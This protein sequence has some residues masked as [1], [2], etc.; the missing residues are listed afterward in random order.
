MINLALIGYGQRGSYL[1]QK[2]L[3][4]ID[5]INVIS[6]CDKYGDRAQQ[7][8]K[9]CSSFG[10][11]A[12]C[13]TDYKEALNVAGIDGAI[14]ATSW[15]THSKIALYALEKGIPVGS[16]VAGEYSV[17][18]CFE[19]VKTQERTKTP[20]MFLENCCYGEEELL[21]TS[22]VRKN[23]L[24]NVVYC[25]GA[26]A[27]DLRNEVAYGIRNRHYRF[28]N[29]VH[30]NCDN[31][32]THE[33][34]PIARLLN[35]NRGNRLVSLT[36]MSS[37][38]LGLKE[39]IKSRD[40]ADDIM[41]NAEFAQGDVV[42]TLIKCAGGEM[43]RLTLDTT[44]PRSYSRHFTVRGTKGN[45]S[46]D[47]NSVFLDGEKEYWVPAEYNEATLNNA[48]N[49]NEYMPKMWREMTDE[50]REKGH[51]G[52]DWF[53]INAFINTLKYK[54][55]VPIDIYDGVTWMAIS[56]LTEKSIALGSQPVDI[57]DF[58]DGK[59]LTRKPEDVI[60]L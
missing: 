54:T 10:F 22:L 43:I 9:E 33:L 40:D 14:I 37:K 60:E 46:Q 31:Y 38:S 2:V 34:G 32:P 12:E 59:W 18:K 28:D 3:S 29:Y 41:K 44:L 45:Y 4:N 42:E 6:V 27:H 16:E 15:D 47:T 55:P 17:D 30:R 21:A 49:F 7:A 19:L 51:G 39:Y 20:Y 56:A 58:T 24:G 57:P 48:K 52:M 13:F 11:T 53:C 50:D 25:S 1:L 35:I 26:Y 36:S 8:K 23:I 5:G